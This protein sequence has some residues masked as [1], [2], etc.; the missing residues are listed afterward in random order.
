MAGNATATDAAAAATSSPVWWTPDPNSGVGSGDNA[1]QLTAATLVGLQSVPGLVVLYGGITKKKWARKRRSR[2]A[3]QKG[4]VERRAQKALEK[5]PACSA[6][7]STNER[8]RIARCGGEGDGEGAG[9]RV[10][11]GRMYAAADM[12]TM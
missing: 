9:G 3:G 2:H 11:A 12:E 7:A 1:W 5:L 8:A 4:N 6:A 10:G